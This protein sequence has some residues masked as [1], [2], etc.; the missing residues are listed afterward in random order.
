MKRRYTILLERN[1]STDIYTVTVP[2]LPGC[3]T[4]ANSIQ[5][6]IERAREVIRQFIVVLQ[7]DG[8]DIPKEEGALTLAT[9]DVELGEL[10]RAG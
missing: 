10:E 7:E 9:V 3:I 1:P 2:M 6:A 5:Q 4:Q 8:E